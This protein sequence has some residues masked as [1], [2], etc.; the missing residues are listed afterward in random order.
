MSQSFALAVAIVRLKCSQKLTC[1][2]EEIFGKILTKIENTGVTKPNNIHAERKRRKISPRKTPIGDEDDIGFSRSHGVL[3]LPYEVLS[4]SNTNVDDLL[5]ALKQLIRSPNQSDNRLLVNSLIN[6]VIDQIEAMCFVK[7]ATIRLINECTVALIEEESSCSPYLNYK[8]AALKK[9]YEALRRTINQ[10]MAKPVY[11]ETKVLE[12]CLSNVYRI[13]S[14]LNVTF[15]HESP[16]IQKLVDANQ[17]VF[18]KSGCLNSKYFYKLKLKSAA[19]MLMLFNILL[20]H[21]FS[22]NKNKVL[23][24]LLITYGDPNILHFFHSLSYSDGGREGNI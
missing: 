21:A 5:R 3:T 18:T 8:L 9:I 14:L 16:S 2:Y 24:G 6:L 17:A 15:D 19:K 23:L 12:F 20:I 13:M 22:R 4:I 1:G 7:I 10:N 11:F